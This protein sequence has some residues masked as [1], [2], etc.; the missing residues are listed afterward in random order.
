M[1]YSF[2]AKNEE[3]FDA[4]ATGKTSWNKMIDDFYHPFHH[5]VEQTI[6]TAARAKGERELGVEPETGKPVIARLGRFG[7]MV[8]IGSTEDTDKP[9]S[10][11]HTSELQSRE[12]LVCRL[13]L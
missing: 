13:L 3:E 8:Q 5:K 1:D 2:T 6:E 7:P 4:I 12:N 9:R 11:E 10:E